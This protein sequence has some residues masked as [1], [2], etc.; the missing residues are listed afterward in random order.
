M[1]RTVMSKAHET[2]S[3]FDAAHV[4]LQSYVYGFI[5]CLALTAAAYITAVSSIFSDEVTIGIIGVLAIVQCIVQLRRF[6]H[7]GV[8][9]KPRWKLMAFITMLL[10]VLIL[11]IGSLWIMNNL[12]Y[13]MIHS[14]EQMKEYVEGQN[15]L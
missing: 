13:R 14:P 7:V 11:V 3:Q 5:T 6:L 10:I 8:E 2:V 9:F 4:S 15:S 12:N 1:E